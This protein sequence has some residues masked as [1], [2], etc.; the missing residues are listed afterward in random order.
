MFRVV[1]HGH[2][3]VTNESDVQLKAVRCATEHARLGHVFLRWRRP[4]VLQAI[5]KRVQGDVRDEYRSAPI[6]DGCRPDV[7]RAAVWNLPDRM[8]LLR[9]DACLSCSHVSVPRRDRF[10]TR[11]RLS[12]RCNEQHHRREHPPVGDEEVS[13]TEDSDS[14]HIRQNHRHTQHSNEQRHQHDVAS[15]GGN[16]CRSVESKEG[17]T[18]TRP[19]KAA[20][21][22]GSS[23]RLRFRQRSPWQA[24]TTLQW[25]SGSP[26]RTIARKS[27]R[28]PPAQT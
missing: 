22:H 14:H 8:R 26:G 24:A 6:A 13:E 27:P 7:D 25:T 23:V 5:Q 16:S 15:D 18:A 2:D 1:G 10:R 3:G 11:S 21:P 4:G 20:M 19:G 17:A 28:S 12:G 9:R